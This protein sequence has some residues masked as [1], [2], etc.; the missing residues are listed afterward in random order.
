[1]AEEEAEA[2]ATAKLMD[3]NVVWTVQWGEA[4]VQDPAEL[5]LKISNTFS[6]INEQN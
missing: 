2:T 4:E 5:R 3:S 1:M 6:K